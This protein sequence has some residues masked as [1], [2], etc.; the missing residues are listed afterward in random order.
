M[1]FL[2]KWFLHTFQSWSKANFDTEAKATS[3]SE[4]IDTRTAC[5]FV[6]SHLNFE[7]QIIARVRLKPHTY[8]T[9]RNQQFT[10]KMMFND[11]SLMMHLDVW[12]RVG[13]ASVNININLNLR[14]EY[15]GDTAYYVMN[16]LDIDLFETRIFVAEPDYASWGETPFSSI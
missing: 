8:K 13:W 4:N 5:A 11:E 3:G 10:D 6:H 15:V 14:R 1:L 12:K 2:Y 7:L 9:Y 16:S